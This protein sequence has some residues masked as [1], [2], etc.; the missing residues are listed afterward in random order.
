MLFDDAVRWCYTDDTPMH[1]CTRTYSIP[2][3]EMLSVASEVFEVALQCKAE[4][5]LRGDQFLSDKA[6]GMRWFLLPS[7]AQL[8]LSGDTPTPPPP[9]PPFVPRDFR[10][11]GNQSPTDPAVAEATE[12][13]PPVGE[14][15]EEKSGS[16]RFHS[17]PKAIF[18]PTAEVGIVICVSEL[19]LREYLWLDYQIGFCSCLCTCIT[20]VGS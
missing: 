15:G 6:R 17:P 1:C 3:Q 14:S 13:C 16:V 4:S 18:K 19:T 12:Q 11:Y 10:S 8:Y 5:S 2:L 7:E 20:F 9:T